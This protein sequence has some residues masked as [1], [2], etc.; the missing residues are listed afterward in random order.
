MKLLCHSPNEK[1]VSLLVLRWES[2]STVCQRFY[3]AFP[4]QVRC[5]QL[6]RTFEFQFALS[7]E[8]CSG[9]FSATGH[10][11]TRSAQGQF[12][13]RRAPAQMVSTI[14][15]Q[16]HLSPSEPPLPS[17]CFGV[18]WAPCFVFVRGVLQ[19]CAGFNFAGHSACY[20][21]CGL[22][23]LPIRSSSSCARPLHRTRVPAGHPVP[24]RSHEDLG[25]ACLDYG[26]KP[27][28][29]APGPRVVALTLLPTMTEMTRDDSTP[30]L[31]NP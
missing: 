22:A 9:C 16:T 28:K 29:L 15:S 12:T 10:R 2:C 24:T 19:P 4:E 6:K 7:P 25:R 8:A 11:T 26:P 30:I 20:C 27:G 13:L 21:L 17:W 5:F 1:N 3:L 31:I 14:S 18:P 23:D